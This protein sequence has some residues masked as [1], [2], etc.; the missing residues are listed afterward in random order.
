V[1]APL[2]LVNDKYDTFTLEAGYNPG[3][4][5]NLYVFYSYE[6][7][8]ILQNGRQSGST[9][10]FNPADVWTSN[11]TNKGN[12]FGAGVDLTVVPEKWFV[13]VW[14]R[15]QDIDGNNDVTLLPGYSTSIYSSSTLAQCVGS[16]GPCAI[17][18]FDDTKF[19]SVYG[20]IRYQFAKRWKA[21]AG[22]G[23]EDYQIKDAQTGN[24]LNYMPASFFLQAN[25]RDYSAWVGFAGVT[26]SNQ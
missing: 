19:T 8:D 11:I 5:A 20:S 10:N 2:G 21:A 24:T 25:N 12:T 23:Y 22:V 14:G 26:Y 6:N 16:A 17:P 4:R 15:Y 1:Q 9:V 18:E 13:S 3:E 7:G